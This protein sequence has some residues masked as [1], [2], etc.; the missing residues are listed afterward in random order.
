MCGAHGITE[1]HLESSNA[2][3]LASEVLLSWSG[4]HLSTAAV[5]R[6]G[7]VCEITWKTYCCCSVAKSCPTICHPVDFSI[8]DFPVLH[9]LPEFAQIHVHSVGV[10]I[11]PS[12]PL[13]PL[14]L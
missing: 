1:G 10:A 5:L 8:P 12:H 13:S 4:G 2:S 9:R 11:Q 6:L 14:F 7:D 3:A